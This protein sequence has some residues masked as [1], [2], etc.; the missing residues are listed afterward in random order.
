MPRL[1]EGLSKAKIERSVKEA[2]SKLHADGNGLYLQTPE[3]SW[4][5]LFRFQ[6]K[7][8][9]MGLGPLRE[10]SLAAALAENKKNRDLLAAGINPLFQRA[11]R[12]ARVAASKSFKEAAAAYIKATAAE[13]GNP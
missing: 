11:T 9:A 13:R 6:S 12:R 4:I 2:K 10:V 7:R 3:A 8:H 1:V 5:S